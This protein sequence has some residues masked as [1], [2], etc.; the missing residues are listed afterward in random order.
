[1]VKPY[2]KIISLVVLEEENSRSIQKELKLKKPVWVLISSN[3]KV[4]GVM[5]VKDIRGKN[6]YQ[7]A[8]QNLLE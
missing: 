4:K 5:R 2:D 7:K 8:L 1:M 3:K 6:T